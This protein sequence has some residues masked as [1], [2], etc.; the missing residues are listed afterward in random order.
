[1]FCRKFL[2]EFSQ[3]DGRDEAECF[4]AGFFTP[5]QRGVKHAEGDFVVKA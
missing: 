3:L 4:G 5:R 2:V 1:M